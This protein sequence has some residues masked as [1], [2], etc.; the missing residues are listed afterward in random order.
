M[1]AKDVLEFAKKNKVEIVDLKFIDVPGLWQHFSISTSEFTE[2]LFE[3]GIGFDGSSIRGFQTIDESDMLL[4]PDPDTAFMDPFTELPT[5][6]LICNVRDPVTGEAY[7]RDPRYV[8]QKAEKYLKSTGLADISYWGP[9]I[10]FYILDSIRFDQSYNYGYYY[11]DSEEGFWNSG[12]GDK[13]NLGYKPRYKEGYFPVPPMDHLQDIRSEMLRTL[14]KCGVVVEIHHH[15]VGTAGQTEID[16]RYT[17]LT[18]MADQVMMYKYIIKNVARKRGKTV[19][20]MPK[21]IFQ[22]NGSGMHTHQSLWK[23]GKNIFYDKKN[24]G[25]I[26][27]T[28][29]HYIGGILKHADALCGIVAPTTNSYRRLVPGYE[30]PI[31]LVYSQRNRSACVRIP[32]YSTSEKA[33]RLEFR[34]P[35]PSCNPYFSFPAQL[36]AGLDGIRNKIEPPKP[37]DKDLYELEPEEAAKVKSVPGS[38]EQVLDAL[39][40]DHDFLLKGDVFTKD[41][42][43]T[44]LRYKRTKEVDAIRL[45]PHPYEFALYYDI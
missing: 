17:T 32:I 25:L 1:K 39:E 28:A 2:D 14:E 4:F 6:S 20:V 41:V 26:S 27:D 21:P 11:I 37:I 33:K 13:P 29:R 40:R 38:L 44:W 7:T 34:T 35:D 23:G 43:E 8:A 31:N 30:A 15:E 42:I 5:L 22:D 10:E 12:N 24:Y 36:M 19:T 18:R 45:R 16:M 9:E 3:N